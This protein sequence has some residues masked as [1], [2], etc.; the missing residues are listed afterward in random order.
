MASSSTQAI[1]LVLGSLLAVMLAILGVVLFLF[2]KKRKESLNYKAPLEMMTRSLRKLSKAPKNSSGSS[3]DSLHRQQANMTPILNDTR[4]WVPEVYNS[5]VQPSPTPIRKTSRL[6]STL[7]RE[8]YSKAHDTSYLQAAD[9]EVFDGDMKKHS[10]GSLRR[11]NTL[12]SSKRDLSRRLA[13]D[14]GNRGMLHFSIQY[15][16]DK[17]ILIVIVIKAEGLPMRRNGER[18]DPFVDL[19]VAPFYKR[20]MHSEVHQK[21]QNPTFNQLFEFEVPPYEI[22]GQTVHFTVLDFSQ[23]LS[24]EP[25]G[26]VFFRLDS[27]DHDA[28]IAGKEFALWK[29]ID[30]DALQP[31]DRLDGKY[32][33]YPMEMDLDKTAMLLL[34]SVNYLKIAERLTVT[35]NKARNLLLV[36]RKGKLDHPYVSVS[37]KHFGRPLKKLRT[38]VVK[39]E[40]NPVF[41]KTLVFDVPRHLVEH[42]SLTVK[43]R[44]HNDMGRDRTFAI[45]TIGKNAVGSGSEQW[46][47]MLS[48]SETVQRWHRLIPIEPV[49]D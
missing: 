3:S 25:I 35:V 10:S 43:L 16:Q 12:N 38:G 30:K 28:F 33:E 47:D 23:Q 2:Y 49:E 34:L 11:N 37:M 1:P 44:H 39:H 5:I 19:Q 15:K 26:T 7:D 6:Q 32:R 29:K 14:G 18:C 31:S 13:S 24:H 17:A 40:T 41:N 21:T 22:R 36:D 9:H 46:K 27:V 45:L 20:R 48:S 4:F 42:V 8:I